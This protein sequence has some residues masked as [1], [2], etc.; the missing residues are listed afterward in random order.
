[1]ARMIEYRRLI[2]AGHAAKMEDRT[3]FKIVTGKPT[4]RRPLR[5]LGVDERTIL[6]WILKKYESIRGIGFV[7]L[8]IGII[9]EL[10]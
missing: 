9:G 1:M 5:R 6:E 10:L 2:W 4:G 3:A 7:R 8:R